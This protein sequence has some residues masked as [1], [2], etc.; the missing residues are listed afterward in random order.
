MAFILKGDQESTLAFSIVLSVMKDCNS[1]LDVI[2][3]AAATTE[4]FLWLK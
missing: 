1:L 2:T 3:K 4:K